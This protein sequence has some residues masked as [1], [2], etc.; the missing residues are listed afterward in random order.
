MPINTQIN[1]RRGTASQWSSTNPV[2]GSGEPGYDITNG[3]LKIGNGLST[4]NNLVALNYK[5]NRG[6]F[7][8]TA[9]SGTFN[10]PEGYT[11]GALDV[12]LNGI[13]LLVDSEYTATNGTSF[14]LT[15]AAPSGSIIEYISLNPGMASNLDNIFISGVPLNDVISTKVYNLLQPGSG[16]NI[17]YINNNNVSINANIN[18]I[19]TTNLY[20]WTNFK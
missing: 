13:K 7:A 2:L 10:V 19:N 15:E 9:S 20:L 12:F 4:W 11:V 6:S 1:L 14:T 5:S 16:I 17:A 18:T 3:I 8:L